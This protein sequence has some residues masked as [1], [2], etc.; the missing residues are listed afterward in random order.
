MKDKTLRA[1]PRKKKS[2]HTRLLEAVMRYVE[3]HHGRVLV[4]GEIEIQEWTGD[5]A[6]RFTVAVNCLGKKPQF[7][8]EAPTAKPPKSPSPKPR[9]VK[10]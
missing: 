4:A 10:S 9:K 1:S 8:P 5:R 6:G 2:E 7:P 3:R